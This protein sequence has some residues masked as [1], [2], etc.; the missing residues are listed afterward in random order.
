MLAEAGLRL[1]VVDE[2]GREVEPV[3]TQ[4]V[5]DNGG[6]RFPAHL[7]VFPP[8]QVPSHRSSHPRYDRMPARA[9]YHHRQM[10]DSFRAVRAVDI[11]HPTVVELGQRRWV[12]M[13]RPRRARS[14]RMA[15]RRLRAAAYLV[16]STGTWAAILRHREDRERAFRR[17]LGRSALGSAGSIRGGPDI[18]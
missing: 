14:I 4:E 2:T 5:R 9:W 6:R 17:S 1:A 18:A 16:W 12:L 3:P 15:E 13:C 11:D 7:D 8:D 10:R